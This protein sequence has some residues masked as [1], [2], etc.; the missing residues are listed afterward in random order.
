MAA[1][2]QFDDRSLTEC[3]RD[4]L[5]RRLEIVS[6]HHRKSSSIAETAR[7]FETSR[8]YIRK[9]LRLNAQGI[10][11]L[12]PK[13]S[14]PKHKRGTGLSYAEKLR[15]ECM[16]REFPDWSHKKLAAYLPHNPSMIYRYLKER[17]LLV[18]DRCPGF[19]QKPS[20]SSPWKMKRIRLPDD[21]AHICPGD[22][23]A[24]D[25]IVE[26]VGPNRTKLYFIC[27]MDLATRIGIAV[28]VKYHSSHA[29]RR[30]LQLMRQVLQTDINA[31][32]TDNG[33]E[34]LG[35]FQIA[36]EQEGITHFFTRPR[37]PK[38]NA[39]AERFNKTLQQGFY[40]RCDLSKPLEEVNAALADWLIEYNCLRPH[41]SLCM[42]P[43]VAVYFRTFYEQRIHTSQVDSRLWNRTKS[44]NPRIK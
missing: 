32:L 24:L 2:R 40:W 17:R 38:D 20:C 11:V 31:V 37:T 6:W 22:L 9:L 43:P 14:G 10:Q 13:R 3:Q 36:C 30:V 16:A 35:D 33:Y 15:I 1:I 7:R 25:S 28:A 42:R 41:E 39:V 44:I 18:R 19:H 23:V 4:L 29:A 34:F 12:A 27:A 8:M 21:Y 5:K 26:Y